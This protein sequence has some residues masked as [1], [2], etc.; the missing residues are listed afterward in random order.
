MEPDNKSLTYILLLFFLQNDD[1]ILFMMR[2]RVP[3]YLPSLQCYIEV[4]YDGY[5]W[6]I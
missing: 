6:H 2:R 3:Y 1:I 5:D 4:N